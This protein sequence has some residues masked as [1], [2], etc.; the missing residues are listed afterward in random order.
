MLMAHTTHMHRPRS[1][2]D[3]PPR[4]PSPGGER[5]ALPTSFSPVPLETGEAPG[6]PSGCPLLGPPPPPLCPPPPPGQRCLHLSTSG[7]SL[8]VS[9]ARLDAWLGDAKRLGEAKAPRTGQWT[10][11]AELLTAWPPAILPSAEISCSLPW[12]DGQDSPCYGLNVSPHPQ[13]L[14]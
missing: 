3:G 12:R 1:R 8:P 11:N 5:T 7:L 9:A 14:C 6:R 4:V 13:F 2:H 10:V